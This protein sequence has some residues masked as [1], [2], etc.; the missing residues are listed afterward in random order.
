VQIVVSDGLNAHAIMDPEHLKP[1]L[2][3]LEK[4]LQGK[5]LT[6]APEILVINNGR[7]RAGYRIGEILFG[8]LPN[9]QIHK[10]VLHIIGERPGT[11]HH[12]FSVYITGPTAGVWDKAGIDHNITRVVSGIADTALLPEA[13]ALQT[14]VIIDELFGN[15]PR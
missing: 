12:A 4:R 1:Y 14:V 8:G 9:L 13:A 5:N 2:S 6:C 10:A 11:M 7:V 3:A 15:G